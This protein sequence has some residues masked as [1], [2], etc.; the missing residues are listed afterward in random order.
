MAAVL[1]R[2][3]Q[4]GL[5]ELEG[6]DDNLYVSRRSCLSSPFFA[7]FLVTFSLNSVA[8]MAGIVSQ[9]RFHQYRGAGF[10]YIDGWYFCNGIFGVMHI[11]A[12]IYI[13]RRLEEPATVP[14]YHLGNI[15]GVVAV[16][17]T[18]G[19][20]MISRDGLLKST[21]PLSWPRMKHFLCEDKFLAGYIIAFLV[22]V[23]WH[24]FADYHTYYRGM[25]FVM[26]CADIFI[27]AGPFS[28]L[29]C[30]GAILLKQR[31]GETI[32]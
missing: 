1:A 28:F 25:M 12:A 14:D 24:S 29:F 26:K 32:V 4:L 7:Y 11:L 20:P 30:V 27:A 9:W 23:A 22:Y 5:G 21:E 31:G 8:V 15:N 17:Q 13:V 16:P 18:S 10:N 6:D 3:L 2:G 19:V